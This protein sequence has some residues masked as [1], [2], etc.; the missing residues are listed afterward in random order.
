MII[1][2]CLYSTP[3]SRCLRGVICREI[4]MR[5]AGRAETRS[6][7][8]HTVKSH[9]QLA[10]GAAHHPASDY[11]S[12]SM[13]EL[14]QIQNLMAAI[15]HNP[16]VS[17]SPSLLLTMVD[18]VHRLPV[19]DFQLRIAQE[20][21]GANL[22]KERELLV[23]WPL[24]VLGWIKL[25]DC[26]HKESLQ[27]RL[28]EEYGCFSFSVWKQLFVW[29]NLFFVSACACVGGECCLVPAEN[30]KAIDF[31]KLSCIGNSLIMF[32]HMAAFS[33]LC[34]HR[35]IYTDH[36]NTGRHVF[37]QTVLKRSLCLSVNVV[38]KTPA[39]QSHSKESWLSVRR[40]L[41]R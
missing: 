11:R 37:I 14:L 10:A 5:L 7:F 31:H 21:I 12:I 41:S 26:K 8:T 23:R 33:T 34:G 25:H 3:P 20:D 32:T 27:S 29:M 22:R 1:L 17:P 30:F 38:L 4:E 2:G 36:L 24:F 19:N 39:K 13:Q 35:W 15:T 9:R 18:A 16:V 40:Y 28:P 6:W